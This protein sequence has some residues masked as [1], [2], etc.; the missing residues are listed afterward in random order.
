MTVAGPVDPETG[1]V[2]DLKALRDLVEERVV[3]DV[4]HRNL[5]R[6]VPWLEGTIPTTENLVVAVWER[7]VDGLPEAVSLE[8]V[9]LWETP[10]NYVE[11]TGDQ[12]EEA[13]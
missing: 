12:G 1:F 10:R 13:A 5:N 6:E 2:M 8:R 3:S 11:Y 9:V 7:I 4:D